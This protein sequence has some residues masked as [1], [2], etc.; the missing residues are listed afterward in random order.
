VRPSAH[1]LLVQISST[2]SWSYLRLLILA[3]LAGALTLGRF[4]IAAFT[5]AW[6]SLSF[7]GLVMIY[8]ISTLP[9][10]SHLTGSSDRTIDALLIGGALL[11]PVLIGRD[12]DPPRPPARRSRPLRADGGRR[13]L[14]ARIRRRRLGYAAGGSGSGRPWTAGVTA[15]DATDPGPPETPNVPLDIECSLVLL[16]RRHDAIFPASFQADVDVSEGDLAHGEVEGF[17]FMLFVPGESRFVHRV[18]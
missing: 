4:R 3:G 6:L 16:G 9:L 12:A 10:S 17:Y 18:I 8:W 1:E 5:V 14:P 13:S 11:V 15:P 2:S 7:A